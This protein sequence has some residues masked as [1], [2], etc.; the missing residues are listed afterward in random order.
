[1]DGLSIEVESPLTDEMRALIA[2]LN[3]VLLGVTPPDYCHHLTVEQMAEPG[4]T[5]F[6]ARSE[7]AIVGC[8]A[9]KR[10][11]GGNGEIKRMFTRPAFQGRGVAAKI[12]VWITDLAKAEGLDRLV[13]ET[14]AGK[15]FEAP[16]RL[17][18]KAGFSPCGPVLGYSASPYTAFYEKPLRA[19]L[20]A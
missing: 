18:E 9:L 3:A 12:L 4:V 6:V 10:H 13:L 16:A 7:G 1:M 5:V 14:G 11:A 8:G 19:A 15:G 20:E 2:E 17:Y